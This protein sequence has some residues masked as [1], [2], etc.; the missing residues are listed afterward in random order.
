MGA[1]F[2]LPGNSN[3]STDLYILSL[4]DTAGGNR[5]KLTKGCTPRNRHQGSSCSHFIGSKHIFCRQVGGSRSGRCNPGQIE[6]NS[7]LFRPR[8]AIESPWG[9]LRLPAQLGPDNMHQH[10]VGDGCP[11]FLPLE[12]FGIAPSHEGY[13]TRIVCVTNL[14]GQRSSVRTDQQ[15]NVLRIAQFSSTQVVE[16]DRRVG[17]PCF[18]CTERPQGRIDNSEIIKVEC[19][20]KNRVPMCKGKW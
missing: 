18:S 6:N 7:A 3:H 5:R 2:A 17:N 13:R 8:N 12:V 11:L 20:H 19:Y 14:D 9:F 1:P 16:S 4:N 15:T 10:P